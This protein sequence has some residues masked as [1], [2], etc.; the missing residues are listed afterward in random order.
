M[1]DIQSQ[2][3]ATEVELIYRNKVKYKDRPKVH[4]PDDAHAILRAAWDENKIEFQEQFRIILLDQSSSCIG[5]S[6]IGAGGISNCLVDPKIVFATALKSRASSLILSHNHPSG[7]LKPSQADI[8]LT[9]KLFRAGQLLDINV[10]DHLILSADGYISM[11][12]EGLMP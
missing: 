2:F 1:P 4:S 10:A 6:C 9:E 3:L 11:A 5:V 12:T 7:N 8:R